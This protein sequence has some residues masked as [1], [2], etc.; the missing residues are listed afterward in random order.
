MKKIFSI[1]F[2][3]LVVLALTTSCS[4]SE[5]TQTEENNDQTV[6]V[7]LIAGSPQVS[8]TKTEMVGTTPYWSIN[9]I[10]GVSNASST[11]HQFA[12]D[13]ASPATTAAFDGEI[14]NDELNQPLYAYHPYSTINNPIAATKGLKVDMATNQSPTVASF[15]GASDLLVSKQFTITQGGQSVS[16]LQF[17]RLGAI[18]KIVL[19][20]NAALLGGQH[21][22]IV[23][24][25]ASG[26]YLTGRVYID[27]ANQQINP[28]PN[29]DG[30]PFYYNASHSVNA[31][32]TNATQYEIDNTNATYV[33]V[34]PQVLEAGSTLTISAETEGFT[35]EK[36]ITVPAGGIDLKEGKIT[37]LNIGL[38]AT[39]ITASAGAA[40]PFIDDMAW[41]NNGTSDATADISTSIAT[42]SAGLYI[43]GSKAYK[44]IGGLKLGSS[45]ANGYIVTK[46]LDLS[47]DFYIEIV[48]EVYGSDTGNLVITVDET[49]VLN[50]A[51]DDVNYVNIPAGTYTNKSRVTIATSTKRGRIYSVKI[52]SGTYVPAP[53]INVTTDNPMAVAN[54]AGSHTIQY[55]INNPTA[56]TLTA[57]TTTSWISNINYATNGQVTFSVAAQAAAAPAR[58]GV[59]TLHYTN[60][61]DVNV[62]VNQAAGAGSTPVVGDVLF[63]CDFGTANCALADYTGGTSYNNASTLTYTASDATKVKIDTGTA[64]NMSGGN[65]FFNGKNNVAGY[66]ATI[67]GIK[68]YGATKVTVFWA[69]N[70]ASSTLAVTESST[71]SVN[72]T[73][74]ASNHHTFNLTGEET[75]ITLVFSNNIAA[76]TRVDNVVVKFGEVE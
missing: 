38:T 42:E 68:T 37:T 53:V 1:L 66:T 70:N 14:N 58:S 40:L 43:G 34:Y 4:K 2:S 32:Y 36:E 46:T 75:T 57:S 12:S 59:I 29:G 28:D 9:D 33:I 23:S 31:N 13:L 72:S 24:M 48:G 65:L 6:K 44:G 60:A 62:T 47:G 69:A 11:N 35:I 5:L 74:N 18:V 25:T 55:T 19:K 73:N 56:A 17:K 67:A 8:G 61:D 39:N 26:A 30:H 51:F 15:D 41:A 3:A 20:D 50:E 21:P 22:S 16:G 54:T 76:N 64:G 49:E 71:A 63:S 45:S 10:I 27:L 52:K 7:T